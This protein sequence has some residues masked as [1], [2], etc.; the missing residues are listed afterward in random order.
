MKINDMELLTREEFFREERMPRFEV[1]PLDMMLAKAQHQLL[2]RTRQELMV[3]GKDKV[4]ESFR[5]P[6]SLQSLSA[7]T[8]TCFKVTGQ[9][10]LLDLIMRVEDQEQKY[11]AK[12]WLE[13]G[14][15]DEM[16]LVLNSNTFVPQCKRWLRWLDYARKN[17]P[18][19]DGLLCYHTDWEVK[20]PSFFSYCDV[21]L[22][23]MSSRQTY[24]LKLKL[25]MYGSPSDSAN[26]LFEKECAINVN[27]P[28][29]PN[30]ESKFDCA[31]MFL[32]FYERRQIDLVGVIWYYRGADDS[33]ASRIII[34]S[35]NRIDKCL[36]WLSRKEHTSED[37]CIRMS[38]LL[39]YGR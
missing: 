14:D 23:G 3:E 38:E 4:E 6:H 15:I 2:R 25:E 29:A 19:K 10:Y 1:M 31:T 37:A 22:Y 16:E 33:I 36:H 32:Q 34:H 7:V 21:D 17:Y 13:L 28:G 8:F 5:V 26:M 39:C 30:D 18:E 35:F 20:T 27:Y 11:V 9:P 12:V 24:E